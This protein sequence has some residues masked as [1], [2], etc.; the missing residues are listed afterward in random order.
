MFKTRPKIETTESKLIEEIKNILFPPL[1]TE[2][3]LDESGETIKYQVDSSVDMNLDAVLID[4]QEGYND[5]P[6]HETLRKIVEKLIKV[7]KL[8]NVDYNFDKDAKYI[9]MSSGEKEK[10][11]IAASD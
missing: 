3:Q 5:G 9:I 10:D 1:Q 11:I 2:T 4:L 6:C 8:L 7:R